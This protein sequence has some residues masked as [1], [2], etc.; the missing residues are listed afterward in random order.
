[1][2]GRAVVAAVAG[3]I[4]CVGC[5]RQASWQSPSAGLISRNTGSLYYIV[6]QGTPGVVLFHEGELNSSAS[7]TSNPKTRT[8]DYSG[9]LTA[10]A[11]VTVPYSLT[12][13]D[14]RTMRIKETPYDLSKGRVFLIN[15]D[16]EILQIPFAPLEPS[17]PYVMRLKEYLNANKPIQATSP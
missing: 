15:A 3:I 2:N 8:F 11:K 12:S 9:T 6:P 16:G 5:S 1:M 13:A 14:P 17:E 4:A 7:H 10:R